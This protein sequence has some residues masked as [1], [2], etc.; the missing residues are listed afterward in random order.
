MTPKGPCAP[1]GRAFAHRIAAGGNRP[2]LPPLARL[3][4]IETRHYAGMLYSASRRL[5]YCS[6]WIESHALHIVMLRKYSNLLHL[7]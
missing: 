4:A 3:D 2:E 7:T 6:E 1:R 5:I